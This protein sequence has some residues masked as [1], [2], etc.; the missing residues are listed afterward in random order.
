MSQA[1]ISGRDALAAI[2]G[3][4][5]KARGQ[6]QQ[7]D[8]ALR[9]AEEEAARLRAD[10]A[11][12]F[13]SLARARLDAFVQEGAQ[14]ELLR[15]L[16][17]AERRALDL[18]NDRGLQLKQQ[19]VA[20]KSLFDLVQEAEAARHA[21]AEALEK[22]LAG[23]EGVRRAAEPTIRA[24]AAWKAQE[25]KIA[26]AEKVALESEKKA[27]QSEEDRE[28]K[29]KPYESDPLFMYLWNAK[30][31]TS[32]YEAG[33][34]A[35]FIDR[36]IARKVGYADAM[37]NYRML[38]EIPLR[39]REHAERRKA[40]IG[41]ERQG[42][43][44]AE[45]AALSEVGMGDLARQVEASRSAL[46][47]AERALSLA[48]R[49]LADFEAANAA[50]ADDPA[51]AQAVAILAEADSRDDLKELYRD[52]ARTRSPDDDKIVRQIEAVEQRL[53]KAEADVDHIRAEARDIARRRAE[54]ERQRD[55]FRGRGYDNP[56]GGFGNGGMLGSILGG[57]LQ[58]AIQGSVLRDALK[59]GYRQRDNPWGGGLGGG[60]GGGPVFGPWTVPDNSPSPGG[61]QWVPPWLDG[62]GG[63]GS[64]GS[65]GGWLPDGGSGG[66]SG[67]GGDNGFRTGGGV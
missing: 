20:R 12:L 5:G 60:S 29:R 22:A 61:G 7:L 30:F 18:V 54:V 43:A 38:N 9:S 16:D 28:V 21:R 64:G 17:N 57:I 41:Q 13:Q 26:A 25:E 37:P 42:L 24:S 35:R 44:Q 49:K 4:I 3:T 8:A 67:G 19:A 45:L 46:I 56:Y 63:S 39:L 27:Q 52:A 11:A 1:M 34:L 6:E 40:A 47:E 65:G 33:F 15:S 66:G 53:A 36:M 62:G 55:E 51:Y 50:S 10:R 31:G 58:G 48:K 23:I 59:D 2:E 32:D 14:P